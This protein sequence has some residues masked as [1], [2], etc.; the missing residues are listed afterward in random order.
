MEINRDIVVSII[1][2]SYR[3]KNFIFDTY[4]SVINQKCLTWEWIIVDDCS[5]DGS[6]EF[7]EHLVAGDSRIHVLKTDK[8]SGTSVARN[9][10]LKFAKGRYITF[11][12]SDDLLDENYLSNQLE[13]IQTNGPLITSSYR[14]KAEHTCTDFIVPE[15]IDYKL[16][17]KGNPMSCLTTMYDR[18]AIGEVY[19]PEDISKAEDYVFWLNILKKGFVA[20]GNKNVLAT[21]IIHANSKSHNK[22]KLIK[23]MY[24]IYHKTQKINWLSSM[25]YVLRW[26]FYGLKKYK[27]VH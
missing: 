6:F 1:T 14:R 26:A 25:F 24:Y 13:F 8:N 9:I 21:Y 11:L 7:I 10:G 23:H 27:N 3:S 22:W 19:F 4:K 15:R 2:P 16:A 18:T 12:D 20:V 17:L 5:D